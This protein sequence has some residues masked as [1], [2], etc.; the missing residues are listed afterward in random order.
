MSALRRRS[1]D[2]QNWL[3]LLNLPEVPGPVTSLGSSA[4][5]T[6]TPA[7]LEPGAHS[8]LQPKSCLLCGGA[9]LGWRE[10]WQEVS[11]HLC[12][13]RPSCHFASVPVQCAW[14][15][16]T[17][18]C[19]CARI[20]FVLCFPVFLVLQLFAW[21]PL[22]LLV[23][24]C[25][26][27][28][29]GLYLALYPDLGQMESCLQGHMKCCCSTSREVPVLAGS[30]SGPLYGLNV[31]IPEGPGSASEPPQ[32]V[33]FSTPARGSCSKST[34][35]WKV[36]LFRPAEAQAQRPEATERQN[37]LHFSRGLCLSLQRPGGS[38]AAVLW[39]EEGFRSF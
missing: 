32:E 34:D 26:W 19:H 23:Q 39:G 9:R 21:Q 17:S 29:P 28:V 20:V 25:P 33:E 13:G 15:V 30:E 1:S 37:Q 22:W 27:V 4:P 14:P 31:L 18:L 3:A 8:G 5:L 36:N 2:A 12:W 24:G 10:A 7:L 6:P 35:P 16:P 11:V 38:S